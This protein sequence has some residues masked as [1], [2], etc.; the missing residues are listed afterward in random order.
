MVEEMWEVLI[1][2]LGLKLHL[3]PMQWVGHCCAI[4]LYLDAEMSITM[5]SISMTGP[6]VGQFTGVLNLGS[7]L[8]V[9]Y[10]P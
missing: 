9:D 4:S 8:K 5:T 7:N 10:F 6:L 2:G 1:V 3:D